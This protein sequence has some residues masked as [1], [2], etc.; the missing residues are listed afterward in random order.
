MNKY[1]TVKEVHQQL[2]DAGI[3]ISR[4]KLY[5]QIKKGKIPGKTIGDSRRVYI[6]ESTLANLLAP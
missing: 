2:R 3:R 4:P 1:L 6:H 5:Q